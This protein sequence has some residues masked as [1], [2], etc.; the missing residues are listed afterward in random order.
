MSEAARMS[1]PSPLFLTPPTPH[2]DDELRTCAPAPMRASHFLHASSREPSHEQEEEEE[3]PAVATLP[4]VGASRLIVTSA[5]HASR[6]PPPPPV[7]SDAPIIAVRPVAVRRLREGAMS[8]TS[9]SR[10]P[11]AAGARRP[12]RDRS[13]SPTGCAAPKV[14]RVRRLSRELCAGSA[15]RGTPPR[16]I[17]GSPLAALNST[18]A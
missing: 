18:V 1:P 6:A 12:S 3:A 17:T 2:A 16:E 15:V 8:A 7:A 5:A 4:R 13:F 10:S 11:R 9:A 14:A